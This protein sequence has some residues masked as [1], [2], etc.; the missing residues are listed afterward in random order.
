[1]N[2]NEFFFD[3]LKKEI[4]PKRKMGHLTTLLK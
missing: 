1:H 3:Y 2:K 4:K